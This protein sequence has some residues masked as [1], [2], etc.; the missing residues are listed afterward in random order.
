MY[1]ATFT[2]IY[3]PI[4]EAKIILKRQ[5]TRTATLHAEAGLRSIYT[6]TSQVSPGANKNGLPNPRG[7]L[8]AQE[9]VVCLHLFPG[10][11]VK[12]RNLQSRTN[13]L[14]GWA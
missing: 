11:S 1:F 6:Q 9:F 14:L 2:R 13:V 10:A 12:Q 5:Q 7:K 3:I 4:L 8:P